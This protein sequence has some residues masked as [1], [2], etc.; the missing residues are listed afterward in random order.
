MRWGYFEEVLPRAFS[1]SARAPEAAIGSSAAEGGRGGLAGRDRQWQRS[2]PLPSPLPPPLPFCAADACHVLRQHIATW[3]S[4]K[5]RNLFQVDSPPLALQM[6]AMFYADGDGISLEEV[7][8]LCRP[9]SDT[10]DAMGLETGLVIQNLKQVCAACS[11]ACH[12]AAAPGSGARLGIP[13][14]PHQRASCSAECHCSAS[15]PCPNVQPIPTPPYP[16]RTHTVRLGTAI[17]PR[18]PLAPWQQHQRPARGH[19]PR[20]AASRA[21]PPR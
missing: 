2:S 1:K 13:H 20:R 18:Q 11:M 6:R 5:T 8:A 10:V 16:V 3:T 17:H 12:G 21:V 9:L 14:L 19:G 15:C 7:D 4:P